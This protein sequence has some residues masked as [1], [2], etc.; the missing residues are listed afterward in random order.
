MNSLHH[1]A[2]WDYWESADLCALD[3]DQ[4]LPSTPRGSCHL[5]V[6]WLLPSPFPSGK[7]TNSISQSWKFVPENKSWSTTSPLW[8]QEILV[9]PPKPLA[10]LGLSLKEPLS[11]KELGHRPPHLGCADPLLK[12]ATTQP[13]QRANKQSDKSLLKW[14]LSATS[15]VCGGDQP[16]PSAPLSAF[17]SLLPDSHKYLS[18]SDQKTWSLIK[19]SAS[20]NKQQII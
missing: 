12:G 9:S 2:S 11:L 19:K 5:L 15:P 8:D 3:W 4:S 1:W 17:V 13:K 18:Y 16:G 10:L 20:L 7:E 6:L 14:L